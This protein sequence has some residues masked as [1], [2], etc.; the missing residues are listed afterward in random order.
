MTKQIAVLGQPVRECSASDPGL[1][2]LENP[3][4]QV[5]FMIDADK[6]TPEGIIS[7]NEAIKKYRGKCEGYVH[8]VNKKSETIVRLG[9]SGR[10]EICDR[11]KREADGILGEG[12]TIYC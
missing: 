5:R 12:S 8:I 7:L 4:K 1:P 11:L 2:A 10:L 3:Y 9:D 6:I